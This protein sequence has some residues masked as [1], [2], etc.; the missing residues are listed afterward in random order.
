MQIKSLG[1]TSY[2][3]TFIDDFS[4]R[5]VVNFLKQKNQVLNN[6]KEYKVLVEK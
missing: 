3:V 5:I 1:R 4:R 6:F 2:I